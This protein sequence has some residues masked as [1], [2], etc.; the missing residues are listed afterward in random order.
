M[1]RA[2]RVTRHG[3]RCSANPVEQACAGFAATGKATRVFTEFSYRTVSKS[4]ICCRRVVAKAQQ[5]QTLQM[6][7][8]KIAASIRVT[9]CK[10]R[11]SLPRSD[12]LVRNG[13]YKKRQLKPRVCR[14]SLARIQLQR[15]QLSPK[16]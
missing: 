11:V 4:W 2:W 10:V 6:R 12:P 5:A 15:K 13:S 16:R 7:V 14:I 8:L 1:C 9:A 3:R